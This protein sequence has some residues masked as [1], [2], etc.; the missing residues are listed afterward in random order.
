MMLRVVGYTAAACV[1]ALLVGSISSQRLV[2]YDTR[3][4]LF[5]FAAL[6]GLINAAIKPVLAGISVPITC[7]T[8]GAAALVLNAGLFALAAWLTPGLRV[9]LVGAVLGAVIASIASGLVFSWLDEYPSQPAE[10]A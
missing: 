10:R 7:L 9:T 6:L 1:A 5:V 4:A 8:F 2:A 3:T